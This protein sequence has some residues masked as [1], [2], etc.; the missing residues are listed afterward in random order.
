M[1][2][3]SYAAGAAAAAVLLT[4]FVTPPAQA[5]P[6]TTRTVNDRVEPG[7]AFDMVKLTARSAPR[8]G[9]PAVVV[10]T[11][12]REVKAGDAIDVWF[13]LDGDKRPD[14]HV[15]GDAFSEFTVHKAKSFSE[16][17]KDISGQ[18]CA[19]LAMAGTTSKVRL[20]PECLGSPISYAV[21]V[22]SSSDGQPESADDWVPRTDKF[23]R[24]VLAAPLS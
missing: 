6:P 23:T 1:R 5:L 14:I 8:S 15:S 21:A 9:R 19:R 7:K 22:K 16:D 24:K 10:V 3:G 17:G 11:H 2:P 13:D 20:F 18:D 4:A 12:A